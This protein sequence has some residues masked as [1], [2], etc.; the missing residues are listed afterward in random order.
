MH[1][2]GARQ[3]RLDR[4]QVEL[5]RGRDAEVPAGAAEAPEEIRVVV[6]ARPYLAAVRGHELDRPQV[7]DRQPELALQPA[8]TAAEGQ[9]GDAGMA[10][11]A[12][13]TGQPERLGSIVELGQQGS[14]VDPRGSLAPGRPSHPSCATCR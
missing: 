12:D 1:E 8:D 13:R 9:A 7:V 14:A 10:D 3:R 5:E 2:P 11:D 6:R 4:V